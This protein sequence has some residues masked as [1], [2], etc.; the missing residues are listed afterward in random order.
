MAKTSR[1]VRLDSPL[2][3]RGGE[4]ALARNLLSISRPGGGIDFLH[5]PPTMSRKPTES[6]GI[7]RFP[8]RVLHYAAYPPENIL[9]VVGKK[10]GWVDE[11]LLSTNPAADRTYRSIRSHLSNLLDGSPHHV[12]HSNVITWAL[13][14]G[15]EEPFVQD[16]A[17]TS[18]RFMMYIF[19]RDK[20][21]PVWRVVL[22]DW[23][24]GDLV[25]MP[26]LGSHFSQGT[27]PG[28]RPLKRR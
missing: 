28:V 9:V 19:L 17:V 12:P 16:L 8:F 13:P 6:W 15:V 24:S 2:S 11:F 23:R 26:Q 4:R 1:E 25:R 18:S 5:V 3:G 27:F 20:S 7:P 21:R 14:P 22:W 10:D